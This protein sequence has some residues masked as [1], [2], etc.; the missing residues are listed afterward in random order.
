MRLIWK[1]PS[2]AIVA[3]RPIWSGTSLPDTSAGE[4][5]TSWEGWVEV[6]GKWNPNIDKC[7]RQLSHQ[8]G[9]GTAVGDSW[10]LYEHNKKKQVNVESTNNNMYETT[11]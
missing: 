2:Y 9:K 4:A 1:L 10:H 6:G 11:N 5:A 3:G 8:P 7:P